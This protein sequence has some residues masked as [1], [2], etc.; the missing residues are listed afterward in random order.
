MR[1]C[2]NLVNLTVLSPVVVSIQMYRCAMPHKPSHN[3]S[4]NFF[5]DRATDGVGMAQMSIVYP[6]DGYGNRVYINYRAKTGLK[7]TQIKI[8]TP[9]PFRQQLEKVKEQKG[10][11]TLVELVCYATRKYIEEVESGEQAVNS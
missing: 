5:C 9:E 6:I 1:V 4:L 8:N 7:M 3:R 11:R 10:F 2:H